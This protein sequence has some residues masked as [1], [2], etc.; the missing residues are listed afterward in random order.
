MARNGQV[1]DTREWVMP[2]L[3]YIAVYRVYAERDE[4][5][6]VGVFHGA[7]ERPERD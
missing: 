7:R 4:V 5:V 3:P 2:R 6:I 1:E